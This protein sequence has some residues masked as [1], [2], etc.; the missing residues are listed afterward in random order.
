MHRRNL[1]G[2]F[3]FYKFED[4]EK[5]QLTVFEDCPKDKQ[6]EILEGM[7]DEGKA[8]LALHLAKVLRGIGDSYN[9]IV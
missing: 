6:M 5:R 1:S 7:C 4:E 9:L 8:N 2:V 3:Y